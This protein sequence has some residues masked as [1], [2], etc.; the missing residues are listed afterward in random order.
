MQVNDRL[1]DDLVVGD[2]E[3]I[4]S[5]VRRRASSAVDLHYFGEVFADVQ[6]VARFVGR[7]ICN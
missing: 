7:L 5:F 6:P 4:P 1:A 3:I 2:I